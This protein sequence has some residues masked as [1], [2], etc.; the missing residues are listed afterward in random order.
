MDANVTKITYEQVI[1]VSQSPQIL[2]ALAVIFFVPLII[3]LLIGIFRSAK[4][5]S[6]RSVGKRMIATASFWIGWGLWFFV[7]GFLFFILLIY[8]IWL[9]L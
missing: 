7:Q 8:P 6:G 1:A 4:T 5:S 3:Y 9:R 2:I